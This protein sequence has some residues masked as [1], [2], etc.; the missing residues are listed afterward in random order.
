M[1]VDKAPSKTRQEKHTSSLK[2]IGMS[3]ACLDHGHSGL[4]RCFG[5]ALRCVVT[6][7]T[8]LC[9]QAWSNDFNEQ[10]A[11]LI[12]EGVTP[13]L[14]YDGSVAS[15]TAGGTRTGTAYV[16]NLRLQLTLDGKQLFRAPGWTGFF[17]VLSIH[18]GQPSN[19]IGDA[20]GVNSYS[21]KSALR[22]YEAWGQYS[23]PNG[24]WS[25]LAG[26]YDLS[27]EFYRLASSGLFLN[28]SF[29]T[30]P[31]FS[32]SGIG[33]PSIF[34]DTSIGTRM[35]Y[36]PTPGILIRTAIMD[37]A[38]ANRV[39]GET[40]FPGQD[41]GLLL[42]SEIAFL[43]RPESGDAHG[44]AKYRVGRGANFPAY[45]DKV[46]LGAWHYTGTFRDLSLV[47]TQGTPLQ[48][49]GSSGAYVLVDRTLFRAAANP[50]SRVSGFLQ[51]GVGDGRVNRIG[52][53]M[54]VGLAASGVFARRPDD[55]FGIAIN[56]ARNGSHYINS[57]DAMT[58]PV[59]RTET[60]IEATY[61]AQ[62]NSWFAVQPDIQYVVHPGTTPARA[63]ATVLQ[64][65]FQLML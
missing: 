20:Q 11:N 34:P 17:Q 50:K 64:I 36:K 2:R 16:G 58:V 63:N 1:S 6:S 26:R 21:A 7:V 49:E 46:A 56:S 31:E 48:H 52:S 29:G 24:R 15:D 55:E 38:P 60:A 9:N 47:S 19:F 42:V 28:S 53:Y 33:G 12:R 65:H 23:S 37:G 18:G 14:L 10:K 30:G 3:P 54:A 59:T 13:T 51:Y 5:V 35:T 43:T 57:Q 40:R 44:I 22:L 61:L 39:I 8:I 25:F 27:S 41:K 4:E 62:V 45:E 32:Q